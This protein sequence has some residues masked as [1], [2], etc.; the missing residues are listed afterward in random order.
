MSCACGLEAIL[1]SVHTT[2]ISQAEGT[3]VR[4][5][6]STAVAE[7]VARKGNGAMDA[8]H[9]LDTERASESARTGVAAAKFG[10]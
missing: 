4:R 9:R 1:V 3:A 6:G 10:V 2:G 7:K 5:L 8:R